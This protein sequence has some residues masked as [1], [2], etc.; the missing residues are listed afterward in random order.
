MAK[1]KGATKETFTFSVKLSPEDKKMVEQFLISQDSTFDYYGQ[2][3]IESLVKTLRDPRFQEE[4]I[5]EE[6]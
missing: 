4:F 5:I 6:K 3:V 2:R 1:K